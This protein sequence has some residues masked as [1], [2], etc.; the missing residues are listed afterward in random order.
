MH[1]KRDNIEIMINEEADDVI[2]ELLIHLKMDIKMIQNRESQSV[3]F[4][5]VQLLYYKCHKINANCGGSYVDS[6]VWIKNENI[7]NNKYYQYER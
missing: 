3:S 2:K 1:L 4:H 5:Y 6:S 7:N